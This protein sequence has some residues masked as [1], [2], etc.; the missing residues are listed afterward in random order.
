MHTRTHTHTH[1]QRERER[2][3]CK[4]TAVTDPEKT[5][6]VLFNIFNVCT[7]NSTQLIRTCNNEFSKV[8]QPKHY[9]LYL[10]ETSNVTGRHWGPKWKPWAGYR[11]P[12]LQ[13]TS[14]RVSVVITEYDYHMLSLHYAHIQCLGI[15][16]IPRLPLCQI[17]LVSRPP[18]LS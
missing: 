12:S 16:L 17:S 11:A 6:H 7:T 5:R 14:Q 3:I 18:L 2:N 10:N 15:I 8:L 4:D 13:R 9:T 1:I